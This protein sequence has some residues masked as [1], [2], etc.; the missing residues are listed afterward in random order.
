MT[1]VVAIGTTAIAA[2]KNV[3]D[4]VARLRDSGSKENR[5]IISRLYASVLEMQQELLMAQNREM[6]LGVT[7]PC[8]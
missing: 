3:T 8:T 1:D 7:M 4:L 2:V 6:E 5:E